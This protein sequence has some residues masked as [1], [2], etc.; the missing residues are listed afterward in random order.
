MRTG[1]RLGIDV[2]TSRVGVA[3]SDPAGTMAIPL[4]TVNRAYGGDDVREVAELAREYDAI[5]IVVGLP[6]H[7]RG[8]E[9]KSA[10]LARSF[11]KLLQK[12]SPQLRVCL[13]DERLSST[14]AHGRLGET[15]MSQKR[16]R[17]IVDQVAAQVILEQALAMERGTN[18]PPGEEV[19]ATGRKDLP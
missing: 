8:E 16:Q 13:V 3:R 11:A 15:G 1:V 6:V 14:Q 2:G 17:T 18:L 5:E 4:V 7:M 19:L 10:R 9:G 12:S